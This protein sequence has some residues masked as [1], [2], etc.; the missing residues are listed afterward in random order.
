[1]GEAEQLQGSRGK[2]L[3]A[4]G[5]TGAAIATGA[6]KSHSAGAA[7]AV[8]AYTAGNF[9]LELEGVKCGFLKS[10]EGGNAVAEVVSEAGSATYFQKKHIAGV[11]Y[12]EFVIQVGSGLAPPIYEWIR[13][14]LEGTYARKDGAI[15]AADFKRQAIETRA[16]ADALV[17][18]IGIP[19]AD[20]ASKEPAYL[21]VAFAP[22]SI[23][24]AP[25]SEQ[26]PGVGK[27][28]QKA[29]LPANFRLE[30]KGL[31]TTR[32]AKVD[33]I[34]IKQSQDDLGE[35]RDPVREPGKLEFPS[36]CVTLSEATAAS[37]IGWHHDFVIAGNNDESKEKTGVL[38][39]LSPNRQ[40]ELLKVHLLGLGIVRLT[41]E[42]ASETTAQRQLK[43]ELYCERIE[44]EP[45][46]IMQTVT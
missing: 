2:F 23:Q 8:R 12:E 9:F 4:A 11:R 1:M 41:R 3:A 28:D 29:W 7:A 42:K 19:A 22:D 30:I 25:S 17:T 36:I 39:F 40:T 31:D 38:T 26:L 43:A 37:W 24:Y 21:T 34:V 33:E 20:A 6:W 44:L 35:L 13:K 32:V 27:A 5:I 15:V 45:L 10:V 46:G 14:T 16:F 18:Q